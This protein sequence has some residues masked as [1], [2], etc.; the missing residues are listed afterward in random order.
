MQSWVRTGLNLY[1]NSRISDYSRNS[2]KSHLCRALT[3]VAEKDLLLPEWDVSDS[4]K[5]TLVVERLELA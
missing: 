1:V 2:Q 5:V 4:M 3:S